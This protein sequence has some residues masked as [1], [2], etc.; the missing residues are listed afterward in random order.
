MIELLSKILS[1]VDVYYWFRVFNE[2]SII[3]IIIP[4]LAYRS[5]KRCLTYTT[6]LSLHG[7]LL[8]ALISIQSGRAGGGTLLALIMPPLLSNPYHAIISIFTI[9]PKAV[10]RN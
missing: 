1:W 10:H 2:L 8:I 4:F 9:P 7:S 3:Y 5:F 6:S